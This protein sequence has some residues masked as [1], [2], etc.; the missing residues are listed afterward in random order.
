MSDLR[1]HRREEGRALDQDR[2]A[3]CSG[4]AARAFTPG[5][6]GQPSARALED[7]AAD[8]A[9]PRDP[10]ATTA[11][12]LRVAAD[13]RRAGPRRRRAARPQARGAVDAPGRHQRPGR[14]PAR[15]D[16]DPRARRPRL[17]G[18]RRP[19]VRRRRPEP[20]LG[21][22]HHLP[23][24]LGGVALSRR[25]PGRL[26]AAGSSAGR[27]PITCAP[28]SSST[29]WRWR[30]R[31][32]GPRRDWSIT[33]IRAANTSSLAFGQT[34]PRRRDRP[35]D[36]QPRR[37]LRQRRRRELLRDAQEGARRPPRLAAQRPSCAARS[38][39][40]SRSST[41]ASAATARSACSRPSTSRTALSAPDGA[42][43]AASRLAS[44]KKMRSTAPTAD[45]VA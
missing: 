27:W 14:A 9:D 39:T 1:V 34:R 6:R 12:R 40:T 15:P 13:P 10:P 8:R 41:T 11:R 16:D 37:L 42:G 17:R 24:N 29:R 28:S 26:L 19:R 35:V 3:A 22:R 20:A 45:A 32:A 23:Q 18:P 2:C 5:R 44:L 21:R 7:R 4:S 30:S 36:G 31:T 38:S 33:P 43:L 25:R